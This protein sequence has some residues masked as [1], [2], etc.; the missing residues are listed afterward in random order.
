MEQPPPGGCSVL[1][2]VA[3]RARVPD[4][5]AETAWG[6]NRSRASIRFGRRRR[7]LSG[8][9]PAGADRGQDELRRDDSP[10]LSVA[11]MLSSPHW[12]ASGWIHCYACGRSS[13]IRPSAGRGI[14]LGVR[15][16]SGAMAHRIQPAS[17]TSRFPGFAPI[18]RLVYSRPASSLAL[19]MSTSG[20][21]SEGSS[22]TS[23]S[24]RS[25]ICP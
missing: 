13:W 5:W 24:R 9:P 10:P 25:R 8:M 22:S 20:E 2:R 21:F 11:S 4:A 18:G 19:S 14:G 7:D 16:Q 1:E 3:F 12:P 15:T 23:S 17:R 6:G